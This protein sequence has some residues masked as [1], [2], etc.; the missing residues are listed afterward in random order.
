M[1][2]HHIGIAVNNIENAQK[3]YEKLGYKMTLTIIDPIQNVKLCFLDKSD[4]PIIELVCPVDDKSPVVSILKKNGAMPY[5]TCY[6]VVD[7]EVEI[8]KLKK[9]GYIQVSKT[10][11]AIAFENRL[12]CFL[13]NKNIGLI[14]LLNK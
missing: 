14:E 12:V 4:S 2:F 10:V 8:K 5:H 9:N 13:Y 1:I 7:I 6:E 3:S 11:P